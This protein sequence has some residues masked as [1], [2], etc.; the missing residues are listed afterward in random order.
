MLISAKII[1]D[2]SERL[3]ANSPNQGIW[4]KN[5]GLKTGEN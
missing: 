4:L 5:N 3:L 1:G 2:F